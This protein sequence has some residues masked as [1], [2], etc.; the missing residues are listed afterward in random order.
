MQVPDSTPA[1]ICEGVNAAM[2]KGDLE[3]ALRIALDLVASHP[4][5]PEVHASLVVVRKAREEWELVIEACYATIEACKK[6]S[7]GDAQSMGEALALL[8]E[9]KVARFEAI[10]GLGECLKQLGRWED[11]IAVYKGMISEGGTEGAEALE[12]LVLLYVDTGKE[13][14]ALETFMSGYGNDVTSVNLWHEY[15]MILK[16]GGHFQPALSA[17]RK[18]I[19]IQPEN[20]DLWSDLGY[21]YLGMDRAE[22]AVFSFKEALDLYFPFEE[23]W[24]GLGRAYSKLG[25]TRVAERALKKATEIAPSNCD[26]WYELG[27]FYHRAGRIA[28]AKAALVRLDEIDHLIAMELESEMNETALPTLANRNSA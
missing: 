11:A 19:E 14:Q 15:G 13:D 6:A 27:S 16:C 5:N 9:K 23:A 24:R 26:N 10:W 2:V 28:E 25:R 3:E 21:V 12:P 8:A 7:V 18:A 17:L 22:E 20:G 1:S 4:D